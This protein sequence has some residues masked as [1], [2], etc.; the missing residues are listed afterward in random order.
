MQSKYGV[1]QNNSEI[2]SCAYGVQAWSYTQRNIFGFL[3]IQIWIVS[4][5]IGI[6][7]AAKYTGKGKLQSKIGLDQQDSE[8]ISLCVHCQNVLT[9]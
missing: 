9:H 6:P 4:K 1:I 7:I 8:N 2:D 3:L 5:S